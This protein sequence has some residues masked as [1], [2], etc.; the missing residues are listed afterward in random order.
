MEC[1]VDNDQNFAH[2][3]RLK[4]ITFQ[5]LPNGMVWYLAI[6]GPVNAVLIVFKDEL[7]RSMLQ[8]CNTPLSFSYNWALDIKQKVNR[9]SILCTHL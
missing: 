9:F 1:V 8:S 6:S 5:R 2:I 4:T 7:F 3:F